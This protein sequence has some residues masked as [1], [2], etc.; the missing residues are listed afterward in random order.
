MGPHPGQPGHAVLK[1]RQLDLQSP[2]VRLGALR[3]DI[4]NQ[5]RAVDDLDVEH[6]FEIALLRRGELV[7]EDHQIVSERFSLV[8]DLLQLALAEIGAGHRMTQ[9]LRDCPDDLD[10]Y[11]L[12]QAR[13]LLQRILHVPSVT[14]LVNGHQES[15]FD[16]LVSVS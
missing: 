8:F 6:F 9:L 3:E 13:Q 7:V 12:G 4:E 14:V 5:R 2:F 11:R 15:M 16:W 10:I 1:L